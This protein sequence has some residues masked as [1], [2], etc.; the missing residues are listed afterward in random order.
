[1][2]G[3]SEAKLRGPEVGEKGRLKWRACSRGVLFRKVGKEVGGRGEGLAW[4][5]LWLEVLVHVPEGL[6]NAREFLVRMQHVL[7]LGR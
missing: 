5:P 4:L 6:P 1:M 7:Q 3:A 2:V